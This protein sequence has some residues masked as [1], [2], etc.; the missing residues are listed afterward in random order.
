ME[1]AQ[2]GRSRLSKSP[3]NVAVRNIAGGIGLVSESIKVRKEKKRM[4]KEG[5]ACYSDEYAG[6]VERVQVSI[7]DVEKM[8]FSI[9]GMN[10]TLLQALLLAFQLHL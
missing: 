7:K 5:G 6:T 1:V 10:L 9:H 4:K 8:N 2:I 3:M